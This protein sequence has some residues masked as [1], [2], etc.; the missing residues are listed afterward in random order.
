ML[1]SK[2]TVPTAVTVNSEPG[3][4]SAGMGVWHLAQRCLLQT[5]YCRLQT[6]GILLEV[7]YVDPYIIMFKEHV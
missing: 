2:V 7:N 5:A 3:P 1:S 6:L 4:G